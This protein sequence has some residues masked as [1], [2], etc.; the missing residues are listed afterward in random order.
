M[1]ELLLTLPEKFKLSVLKIEHFTRMFGHKPSPSL[2]E[3]FIADYDALVKSMER[4][5][6]Q[7]DLG[8]KVELGDVV[9]LA[10]HEVNLS[11]E[12]SVK[13]KSVRD[14]CK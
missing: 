3:A 11:T 2:G 7:G 6:S 5:S 9:C 14:G 12:M 8:G 13:E 1:Q 4:I 10:Q